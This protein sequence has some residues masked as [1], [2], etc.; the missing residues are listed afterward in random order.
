VR[1]P[2]ER[3]LRFLVSRKVDVNQALDRYGLPGVGGLWTAET[4]SNLRSSAP[5][6]I[7][8]Y[9]D[10]DDDELGLREGVLEWAAQEGF[11]QLWEAQME[12]GGKPAATELDEA[13]QIFIN[14]FA[15]C[16]MGLLLLSRARDNEII[17]LIQERFDLGLTDETISFYRDVF[18]DVRL[19]NRSAWGAFIQKLHTKEERHYLSYGLASPTIEEVRHVL[20]LDTMLDPET[21]LS[22]IMSTSFRRYKAALQEVHPDLAGAKSWAELSLKAINSMSNRSKQLHGD[23]KEFDPKDFGGMFSVQISKSSHMSLTDLKGQ[24]AAPRDDNKPP[25]EE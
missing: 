10:S 24:L 8:H 13:F 23:E 3:F 2:Y 16:I 20:G 1:Y 6:A 14:P 22:Q 19:V 5:D 15:R 18:W 4:K 25:D 21:I 9:L 11:R 12:F 7:T 17:E